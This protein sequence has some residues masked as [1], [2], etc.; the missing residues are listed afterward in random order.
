MR[1]ALAFFVS[2]HRTGV[3][4]SS[5]MVRVTPCAGVAHLQKFARHVRTHEVVASKIILKQLVNLVCR[6]LSTLGIF[7]TPKRQNLAFVRLDEQ[8]TLLAFSDLIPLGAFP[9]VDVRKVERVIE[10]HV[11]RIRFG[12]GHEGG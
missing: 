5:P 1:T 12:G 7:E 3:F 4:L 9:K 8:H 11:S 2:R 10:G 6:R